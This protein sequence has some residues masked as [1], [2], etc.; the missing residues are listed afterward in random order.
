MGLEKLLVLYQE[1]ASELCS[2]PINPLKISKLLKFN[3]VLPPDPRFTKRSLLFSFLT[4]I[5]YCLTNIRMVY[6]PTIANFLM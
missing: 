3:I 6:V 1:P 5:S 2:V 4:E